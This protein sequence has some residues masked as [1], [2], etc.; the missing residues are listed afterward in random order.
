MKE[1]KII[2]DLF[3]SYIDDL[4]SESTNQY[5]QE[6]LNSCKECKKVL[7]DMK[8][9]IKLD[10]TQ[11]DS[12]EVKYI[13][14]FNNKMKILKLIIIAIVLTVVLAIVRNMMILVILN[15][16]A[17]KYT[18]YTNY[19]IKELKYGGATEE[20]DIY[21]KYVKDN[22]YIVK[23]KT[24]SDFCKV[25]SA[26]Y[27]NGEVLNRYV[28][29]EYAEENEKN[30]STKTAYL[31]DSENILFPEFF[32]EL[33]FQNSI[34]LHGIALIFSNITSEICNT[35][36]CYR[37]SI[38][39][40]KGGSSTI[41]YV[42]KETGLTVRI[43]GGRSLDVN[44]KRYDNVTDFKYKFDFVTDDFFIEPDISEYEI[45]E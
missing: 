35:Q 41:Y 25:K 38:P 8:K 42:D 32:N 2:R 31:N 45:Q 3:P 11:K 36:E 6:H 4:T 29:F 1:C 23:A 19:Y 39:S 33:D 30:Q 34:Q 20:I 12:K 43:I 28:E 13:K 37:V 26:N 9:D 10:T 17:D 18:S 5:I 24:V 15:N 44:G 16:R 22:K 14:K 7:E 40:F 27:Y 21:E